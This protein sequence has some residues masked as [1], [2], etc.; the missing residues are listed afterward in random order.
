MG[1]LFCLLPSFQTLGAQINALLDAVFDQAH[2][3]DVRIPAAPSVTHRVADVI[4]ELWP[5]TATFALGHRI[6]PCVVLDDTNGDRA[7]RA[8]PQLQ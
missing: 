5:F 7:T 6:T 1:Q 4:S 3:L 8:R 2:P